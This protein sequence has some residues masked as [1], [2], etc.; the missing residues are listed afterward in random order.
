MMPAETGFV[1][2]ANGPWD[3]NRQGLKFLFHF[4]FVWSGVVIQM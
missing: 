2:F 3:V 1:S 4:R